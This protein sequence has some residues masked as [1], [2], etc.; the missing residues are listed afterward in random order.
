VFAYDAKDCQKRR[1]LTSETLISGL[2]HVGIVVKDMAETAQHFVRRYGYDIHTEIIHDPV[3]TAFVQFLRLANCPVY[4]EL[5]APDSEKS[6]LSNSLKKGGGL[7]HLCY[8]TT[9]IDLACDRLRDR[10]MV[11]LQEP[12]AA[13]AF[14][15][16]RI[17]WLM[18]SDSVPVELLEVER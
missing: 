16:R 17:A 3:Q 12:V 4:V 5:V 13:I 14:P 15:G 10:E 1:R 2:H 18:A 8:L 6:K 11:V 9:D 7:N